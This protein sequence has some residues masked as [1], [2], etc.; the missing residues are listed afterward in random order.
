MGI[1]AHGTPP[2]FVTNAEKMVAELGDPTISCTHHF[3][4][5]W[6]ILVAVGLLWRWSGPLRPGRLPRDRGTCS[7]FESRHARTLNEP[8]KAS[9]GHAV[10]LTRAANVERWPEQ[11]KA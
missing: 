7:F 11:L 9:P 3:S 1:Q 2:Y 5:V 6:N 8:G 10:K 4:G